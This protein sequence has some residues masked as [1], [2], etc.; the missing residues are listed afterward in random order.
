MENQTTPGPPS[1]HAP[2][3]AT[4]YR[5]I[6]VLAW[7]L[8]VMLAGFLTA[9]ALQEAGILQNENPFPWLK[10]LAIAAGMGTFAVRLL[11]AQPPRQ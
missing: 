7:M 5:I 10:V 3:D 11:R 1:N 4:T 8:L 9:G 2:P 6:R